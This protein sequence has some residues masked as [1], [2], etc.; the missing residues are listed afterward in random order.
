MQVYRPVTAA[1]A[2]LFLPLAA[3]VAEAPAT[4]GSAAGTAATGATVSPVVGMDSTWNWAVLPRPSVDAAAGKG[5][6]KY[7]LNF[8]CHCLSRR[9]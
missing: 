2:M 4:I 7:S 5:T 3:A 8:H 6:V 9:P 1:P